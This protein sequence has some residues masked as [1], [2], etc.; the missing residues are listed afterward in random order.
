MSIYFT[1][2]GTFHN[3][4]QSFIEPGM[5]VYLEKEP[6]N[7][8]DKEAV[9]VKMEALGKIGY[10]A[11]SPRTVIGECYSA[12]RL[13]D[14]FKDKATATVMYNIKPDDHGFPYGLVCKLDERKK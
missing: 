6:H 13:Y 12:G 9:V 3:I 14:K 5:K 4:G 2:T 11:N 10:V 1:V 8:H 7:E